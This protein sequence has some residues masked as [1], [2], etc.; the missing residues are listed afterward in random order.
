M[1]GAAEVASEYVRYLREKA[2]QFRRFA[3]SGRSK[4]ARQ[5]LALADEFDAEAAAIEAGEARD[6]KR[7]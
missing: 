6:S 7:D 4:L 5:L 3:G 2:E 1:M